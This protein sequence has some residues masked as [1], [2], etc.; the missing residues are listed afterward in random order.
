MKLT[1]SSFMTTMF[2]TPTVKHPG[3]CHYSVATGQQ[4]KPL[5]CNSKSGKKQLGKNAGCDDCAK[6][7]TAFKALDY[8]NT[9]GLKN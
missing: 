9:A 6:T 2:D 1:K 4:E 5:I 3:N 8:F 7:C